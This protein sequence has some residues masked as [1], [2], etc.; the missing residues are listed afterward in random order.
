MKKIFTSLVLTFLVGGGVHEAFAQ[1]YLTGELSGSYPAAEYSISGNIYVLPKT[2]L[3]FEPGS[4]LRFD[5]FTGIVVRGA[6]VCKGTA[7][8]PIIMTSSRDVPHSH[9]AA[10]AFDWNGIKATPETEGITLENCT[11]AYSTFGLNIES[12]ATPVSI[13]ETMFHNNGSASL[14]REKKMVAVVENLPFTQAWPE[15]AAQATSGT[16]TTISTATSGDTAGKTTVS[17]SSSTPAPHHS[18]IKP[19]VR[20]SLG[21]V[22]VAG[23]AL[24]VVGYLQ[25]DHY[26]KLLTPPPSSL[27]TRKSYLDSRDAGVLL[28]NIG[29]GL[30]CVGAAGFGVTFFF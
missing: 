2:T 8:Q 11:I 14:T 4:I 29:V 21:G 9:A 25:A 15:S 1:K 26:N 5:N 12:S 20:I 13:K 22:A 28:R 17:N 16:G 23:G 3:T 19:V 24:W 18:W 27:T 7:D 10:E 30:F 6:F